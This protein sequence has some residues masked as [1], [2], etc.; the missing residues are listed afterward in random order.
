MNGKAA[1]HPWDFLKTLLISYVLSVLML[2]GLAFLMYHMKLG[3]AEATWGVMVIYMITCAVGGFLTGRRIGSR[4][5][6]WGLLSGALYFV[7]LL[8]ISLLIS[9]GTQGEIRQ[10]LTVLAA[11]LAGSAV[12]AFIS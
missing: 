8:V 5:L 6:F 12:G 3:E 1:I 10:I 4:R 9:G 11:C 7:V 2:G